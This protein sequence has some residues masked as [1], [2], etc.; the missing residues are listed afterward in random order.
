M[1][2]EGRFLVACL[3]A[4]VF[5][6]AVGA[7][8][9]T[10]QPSWKL[11]DAVLNTAAQAWALSGQNDDQFALMV[12]NMV[13]V[14]A[15]NRGLTLANEKAL[16]EQM[17]NIVAREVRADPDNLLYAIVD[18]AVLASLGPQ[19][20]ATIPVATC[21]PAPGKWTAPE[22]AT[23]TVMQAW[24][25][26]GQNRA[27]F[28]KMLEQAIALSLENRGLALEDTKDNGMHLGNVLRV[29]L[30]AHPQDLLYTVVDRSVRQV[31][32]VP[33]AQ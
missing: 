29:D 21:E 7:Q 9:A 14:V 16:G 11:E 4:G 25:L 32:T 28:R 13:G 12:Q 6:G 17:G 3:I 27:E 15:A 18:H 8:Q 20:L 26:S 30:E 19:V 31:A 10:I 23:S 33:A 24:Q 22:V 1:R 2:I 5:V